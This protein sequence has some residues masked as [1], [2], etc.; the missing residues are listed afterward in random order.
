MP[1]ITIRDGR[2]ADRAWA[3]GLLSTSEPWITLRLS[4][5]ACLRSVSSPIDHLYIA[6][7]G[8]TPCGLALVREQGLAGAP[9]LVSIAVADAFRGQGIG[10][11]ILAFVE[12]LY[13]SRFRHLFLCVSSFNT[14]ARTFYERSGYVAVGLLPDFIIEGADEVLMVKR[15]QLPVA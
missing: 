4:Y 6:W 12:G 9:Y 14:R 11:R 10:A 5:N 2:E 7:T 8:S 3:A 1:D 15:L 13:R